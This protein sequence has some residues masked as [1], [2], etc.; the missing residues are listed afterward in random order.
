MTRRC[1]VFIALVIAGQIGLA[2]DPNEAKLAIQKDP[3]LLMRTTLDGALAVLR[4]K[5]LDSQTR[6]KRLNEIVTPVFDF[7]LMAQL[8]L[9]KPHWSKLSPAQQKRFTE[10]FVERL[11]DTYREKLAQYTDEKVVFKPA[12]PKDK[13][14]Q[15][16]TEV[17]SKDKSLAIVYSLY[18]LGKTWK[19]YDVEIEGISI[20]RTYRSQFD[21]V[22]SKGTVEDLL[23]QLEKPQDPNAPKP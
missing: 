15:I 4:N 23:I 12:I 14:V 6:E 9:G 13:K 1:G 5:D 19:I 17:V 10:L 7:P 3:Q 16:P 2:K 11:K 8:S 21:E 20:I 22:L 18:P